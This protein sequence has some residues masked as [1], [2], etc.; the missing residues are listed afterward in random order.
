MP[1]H[2]QSEMLQLRIEEREK[3]LK[4]FESKQYTELVS[5]LSSLLSSETTLKRFFSFSEETPTTRESFNCH[6]ER[7]HSIFKQSRV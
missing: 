4:V 6:F 1:S 5:F 2:Q 7:V 3:R